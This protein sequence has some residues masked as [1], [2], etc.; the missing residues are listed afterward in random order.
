VRP[1]AAVAFGGSAD[2]AL[3]TGADAFA[4]DAEAAAAAA[5]ARFG[6]SP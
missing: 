1:G 5:R 2:R 6:V 3:R 4:V